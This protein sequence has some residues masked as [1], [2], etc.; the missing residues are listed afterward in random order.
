ME[1][2][3]TDAAEVESTDTNSQLITDI[4]TTGVRIK[5]FAPVTLVAVGAVIV[6]FLLVLIQWGSPVLVPIMMAMYIAALCL[7]I[8]SWLLGRGMRKNIALVVMLVVVLLGFAAIGLLLIAGVDRV[9]AG[10]SEYAP[11]LNSQL[12]VIQAALTDLGIE[13]SSVDV[14]L[15]SE[16]VTSFL[17]SFLG[18]ISGALGDLLFSLIL[19]AF[20]LLEVERFFDLAETQLKDRP[21]FGQ[22][23]VIAKTAVTYFGIRTRLNLLTGILVGLALVLLGVDYALLWGLLAF[24]LCYVPYIGLF[25]AMIPPT[26]LAF[27]EYGLTRAILVI[28]AALGINLLVENVLEPTYT[29]AKLKLSPTIVFPSFFLWAWL[30]GPVGALLSMPITV[31]I[32]LALDQHESTRWAARIMGSVRDE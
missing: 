18:T 32:L 11:G 9:Q 14:S 31:M 27:A 13:E 10:L 22:A 19:V 24:I 29:G 15:N 3:I 12:P 5:E 16:V 7:P 8:Y 2:Q 4:Q 1:E 26:I 20:F 25:T 6:G 21:I 17:S 28:V 23:P 30:L